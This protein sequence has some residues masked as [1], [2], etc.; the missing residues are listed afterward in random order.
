MPVIRLLILLLILNLSGCSML[1]GF[2]G[3]GPSVVQVAQ[4]VDGIK[5]AVDVAASAGTGKTTTDH[6][7]SIVMNLECKSS[8]ILAG[9]QYCQRVCS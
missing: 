8:R 5:L 9:E 7:V 2:L 1:A 3:A 6:L 4:V